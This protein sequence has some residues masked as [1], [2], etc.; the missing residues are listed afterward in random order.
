LIVEWKITG[1]SSIKYGFNF[2]VLFIRWRTKLVFSVQHEP[3]GGKFMF[4]WMVGIE[5]WSCIRI[6]WLAVAYIWIW[7]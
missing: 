3:V 1:G 7:R 4:D 5:S 2:V 6:S